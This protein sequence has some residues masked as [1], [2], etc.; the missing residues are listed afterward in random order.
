MISVYS[1]KLHMR[2]IQIYFKRERI[3][4]GPLL[5]ITGF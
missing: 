1:L 3:N 2:K 5:L 4:K